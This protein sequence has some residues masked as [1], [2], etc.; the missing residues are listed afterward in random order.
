[1]RNI[2]IGL[3][4]KKSMFISEIVEELQKIYTDY[5]KDNIYNS[6]FDILNDLQ[7]EE[8][9]I[10]NTKTYKWEYVKPSKRNKLIKNFETNKYYELWI[11]AISKNCKLYKKD[12]GTYTL[13]TYDNDRVY[14]KISYDRVIE[15][16]EGL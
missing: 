10:G 9:I 15:I 4:K 2:I 13:F 3:L 1:M 7:Q 5:S 6:V 14:E 16:L 12:D 8:I 11:R